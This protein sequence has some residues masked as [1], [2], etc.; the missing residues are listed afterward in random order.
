M[1]DRAVH[2]SDWATGTGLAI[3]ALKHGDIN[4]KVLEV[5]VRFQPS[6]LLLIHEPFIEE[7][8]SFGRDKTVEKSSSK[9][10]RPAIFC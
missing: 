2:A 6:W 9:C 4:A 3:D 7:K 1:K 5:R 8:A 10:Q